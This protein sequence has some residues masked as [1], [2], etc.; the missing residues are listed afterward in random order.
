MTTPEIRDKNTTWKY[1]R[2]INSKLVSNI[3]VPSERNVKI[4]ADSR[5]TKHNRA[6]FQ[7]QEKKQRHL[8]HVQNYDKQLSILGPETTR[9]KKE[10]RVQK[11]A[12]GLLKEKV[13]PITVMHT[14]WKI[15]I[16]S[17]DISSKLRLLTME[18]PKLLESLLI[19]MNYGI[20]KQP[21]SAIRLNRSIHIFVLFF[22][23]LGKLSTPPVLWYT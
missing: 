9:F 13:F 5:N 16:K 3:D 17:F 20:S 15:V 14:L 12:N 19:K 6:Y 4:R 22:L 10:T 23:V 8:K 18:G 1:Q 11:Q 21:Q 2:K 7:R